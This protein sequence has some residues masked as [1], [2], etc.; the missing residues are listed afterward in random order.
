MNRRSSVGSRVDRRRRRECYKTKKNRLSRALKLENELTDSRKTQ[1]TKCF[2]K[3]FDIKRCAK[4]FMYEAKILYTPKTRLRPD[5]PNDER[6]RGRFLFT[7]RPA[8]TTY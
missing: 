4:K 5:Q 6:E 3:I 8:I 1:P 2:S 7:R